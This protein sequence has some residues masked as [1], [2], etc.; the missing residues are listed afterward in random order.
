MAR[1][2]LAFRI[3]TSILSSAFQSH[4]NSVI[5]TPRLF[6]G[7]GKPNSEVMVGATSLCSIVE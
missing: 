3:M 4:R 2:C 6:L 5:K 1:S 7:T